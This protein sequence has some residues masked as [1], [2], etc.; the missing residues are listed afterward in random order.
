MLDTIITVENLEKKYVLS[1]Q[2]GKRQ[3]KTLRD[4]IAG[5]AKPL[6]QKLLKSSGN[7]SF[8]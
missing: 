8:L 2:Q 3:Y 5:T 4:A 6:S 1:Q 7:K